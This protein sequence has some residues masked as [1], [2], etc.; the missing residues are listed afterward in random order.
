LT[1]SG[2]GIFFSANGNSAVGS[3]YDLELWMLPLG[4]DG[5]G[6]GISDAMD[7]APSNAAVWAVPGEVSNLTLSKGTSTTLLQWAVP[8]APGGTLPAYDA[9]RATSP[10]GFAGPGATCVETN[11]SADRSASD[12]AVPAPAFF[13]LVRAGNLCGEGT[14]GSASSG[15]VRAGRTCP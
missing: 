3:P 7:C 9:L 1:L 5:D 12:A 15:A 4:T 11:D 2:G 6:D 14:L 13:Y 8:A 10:G